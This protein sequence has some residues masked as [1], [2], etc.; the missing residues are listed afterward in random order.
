MAATTE[1]MLGIDPK[2]YRHFA[3]MTVAISLCVAIFADG[4]AADTVQQEVQKRNDSAE[5][6]RANDA[7]FGKT[8]LVDNR[9]SKGSGWGSEGGRYGSP[10]DGSPTE[11]TFDIGPAPPGTARAGYLVNVEIDQKALAAMTPTQRAAFLKQMAD[12]K[13]KRETQGPYV[14]NP[15]Q[16]SALQAASAMRSGSDGDD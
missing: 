2:I 1:H 9:T 8:R 14:P 10:M 7:K 15:A 4:D 6:K 12:E 13:R 16:V 11:D 5:L 3:A